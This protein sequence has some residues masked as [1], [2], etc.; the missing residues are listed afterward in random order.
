MSIKLE[1]EKI[2][3]ACFPK[4]N[5]TRGFDSPMYEAAMFAL[6]KREGLTLRDYY[7]ICERPL[8]DGEE[9]T[10]RDYYTK[11]RELIAT[12][13]RDPGMIPKGMKS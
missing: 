6:L 7:A 1:I 4:F 13:K 8:A 3:E 12:Y 2:R 5:G 9:V 11:R 10:L